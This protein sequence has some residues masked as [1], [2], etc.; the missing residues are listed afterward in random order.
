VKP[1]STGNLFDRSI[2]YTHFVTHSDRI[3]RR[4]GITHVAITDIA[5]FYGRIYHHR[6]DNALSA[7]TTKTNHVK[8]IMHLLA[9]LN[10][11]ETFGIPVGSAPARVLAEAALIDVDEALLANQLTYTRT[12]MTSG[13]SQNPMRM[14][15]GI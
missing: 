3:S 12:T 13:L 6:L 2:S 10:G 5:D 1:D 15:T 14:H 11:T 4:P 9:G 8:A 7:A